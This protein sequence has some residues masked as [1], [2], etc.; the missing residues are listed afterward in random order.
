MATPGALAAYQ[1]LLS[2]CGRL[3]L[4]DLLLPAAEVAEG[5]FTVTA[6]YAAALKQTAKTLNQFAGS[7]AVLLKPDGSPCEKGE[8]LAQPDLGRTY[9]AIAEH[10]A[11]WFYRGPF[12]EQV[13]SWMRE[14]GG[15]LTA[16]DFA[17]YRPVRRE[18]I[19]TD[20][21]GHTVVGFPPPSSGGTHVAQILNILEHFELRA[22]H[23]TDDG[24]FAHVMA[25]AMK[26]AFADRAYWL[27]DADFV[28]VPRGLV[29]R[30]YAAELAQRINPDRATPVACQGS[31]PAADSDL[32]RRHTTHIAA[33][34]Q[35]RADVRDGAE[36]IGPL[37]GDAVHAMFGFDEGVSGYFGS[38]R[39]TAG[40]RFGLQIFGSLGVLEI[41]TGY[42]PAVHFLDDPNWSPGRS[43]KNWVSVS[44]A[45]VGQPEP[46]K[47]GGLPAG[48]LA[49]CIDLI[50][51]I[52]EDRQ[53][54][55]NIYEARLTVAMIT[56]VFE[57][58]RVGGPVKFP[59]QTRVN[60]LSL[61]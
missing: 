61:L 24:Q 7:R 34:A 27:G 39:N 19:C 44:S 48:N 10:G 22:L 57:S 11:D 9:R 26:L 59:L 8:I 4:A 47:D 20:Y 54:E 58:Q 3:T 25:E 42:L 23:E 1:Q 46:L 28:D 37:T 45:G 35:S 13:S 32:F 18:P 31:P 14:N 50:Q 56:A 15:L 17:N 40:G 52:E 2:T 38:Q 33:A 12:A 55:A 30:S 43:G 5:G 36:G 21:R 29:S 41:L 51:A 6:G 49:A 60:P 53:P 16:E